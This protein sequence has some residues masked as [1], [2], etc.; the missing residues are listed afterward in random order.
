[1]VFNLSDL[2]FLRDVI[3][4]VKMVFRKIR[5]ESFYEIHTK[6]RPIKIKCACGYVNLIPSLEVFHVF[7]PI[8]CE[9]CGKVIAEPKELIL[10]GLV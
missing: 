9:K 5:K 6:P 3:D 1:M 10:N 4:T 8:K 2:E 7:E